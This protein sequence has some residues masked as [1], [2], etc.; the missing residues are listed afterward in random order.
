MDEDVACILHNMILEFDSK[1][2]RWESSAN[3]TGQDG[4]HGDLL[5]EDLEAELDIIN[6]QTV[7]CHVRREDGRIVPGQRPVGPG[8]DFSSIGS[9]PASD[10][11]DSGEATEH[12]SSYDELRQALVQH[13]HCVWAR[14]ELEWL[15]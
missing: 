7:P 12:E 5:P 9:A 8:E 2:S 4:L 15:A 11:L 1:D 13:Y 14:K 3:W 6:P 10:E